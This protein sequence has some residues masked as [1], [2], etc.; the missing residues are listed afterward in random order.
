MALNLRSATDSDIRTFAAW[1]YESPYDAYDMTMSASEA[2]TYFSDPGVH[3]STLLDGNDVV[4]FCTFGEDARVPGGDYDDAGL[5]IGL[6]IDPARTGSGEGHR[7]VA[8]VIAHA[9]VTFGP[10]QLRV[11]IAVGNLRAIRV[12]SGAGFAEVSRFATPRVLMGS[13]EFAILALDEAARDRP[14][15]AADAPETVKSPNPLIEEFWSEFVAA[16]GIDGLYEA[17]AFGDASLA[18]MATELALLVR[19]GPKRATAG[20]AAE[21][22]GENESLPMV[23]D[24][25][26]ILDGQG[27]PVCVIRTT[28]VEVRRFGDVDEAFA[29]DEGEGDRTLAWWRRAHVRFF[30][31]FGNRVDEE[32]PMVLERFELLW[33]ELENPA[34]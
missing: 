7:F 11:T 3:C 8:A 33:P 16:T 30:E 24:L 18:D 26:V 31:R 6:G 23:G 32:T 15:S 28:Q 20:L 2:I 22:E 13:S 25:S 17:W 21:Y 5:D 29:R 1:R 27:E 12:W 10:R 9:A 19:D 14:R 34:G 4:G